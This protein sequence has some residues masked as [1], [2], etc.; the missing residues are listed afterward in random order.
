[1]SADQAP[2]FNPTFKIVEFKLGEEFAIPAGWQQVEMVTQVRKAGL[3]KQ[4][5]VFYL[6]LAK[7]PPVP[8]PV[9]AAPSISHPTPTNLKS[10][11]TRK[12]R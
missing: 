6:V 1:M 7:K 8:V 10:K 5:S 9:T 3:L 12:K 11:H 4:Q 2:Q